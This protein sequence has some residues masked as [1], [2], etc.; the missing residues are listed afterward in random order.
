LFLWLEFLLLFQFYGILHD[1]INLYINKVNTAGCVQV[2]WVDSAYDGGADVGQGVGGYFI[3]G[4]FL[5]YLYLF[6]ICVGFFF[7]TYAL[8]AGLRSICRG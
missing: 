6:V 3:A 7:F 8:L 5:L 1:E 2:G 4:L